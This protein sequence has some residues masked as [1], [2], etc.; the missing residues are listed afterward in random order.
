MSENRCAA[1]V[2]DADGSANAALTRLL[3]QH[4]CEVESAESVARA[5][6]ILARRRFDLAFVDDAEEDACGLVRRLAGGR[7]RAI[8]GMTASA[9]VATIAA[10]LRAGAV[11]VLAKPLGDAEVAPLVRAL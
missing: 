2:V 7:I 10:A 8:F 3:Q 4:G 11:D 9:R 6:E 1:L 5:E